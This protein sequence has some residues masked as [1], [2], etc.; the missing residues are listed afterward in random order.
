MYDVASSVKHQVSIVSVFNLQQEAYNGVC[1][2]A[3][4]K[5]CSSLKTDIEQSVPIKKKKR[6]TKPKNFSKEM[7]PILKKKMHCTDF[8]H[9]DI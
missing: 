6:Q 2:H 9:S 4:N 5:V 1:C 3:F 7:P 8:V